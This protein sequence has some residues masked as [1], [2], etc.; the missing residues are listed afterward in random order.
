SDQSSRVSTQPTEPHTVHLRCAR[1][2]VPVPIGKVRE[3]EPADVMATAVVPVRKFVRPPAIDQH[4]SESWIPV[5]W[6]GPVPQMARGL[7]SARHRT[8]KSSAARTRKSHHPLGG[9]RP[10]AA[11]GCGLWIGQRN[12]VAESLGRPA[13][14]S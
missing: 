3:V 2:V 13:R 14:P 12:Q 4:G 11:T 10:R 1:Y 6:T 7:P 5:Y 9:E 8:M